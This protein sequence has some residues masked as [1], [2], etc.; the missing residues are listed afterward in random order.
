[1]FE[2]E[3]EPFVPVGDQLMT[4]SL[5]QPAENL[6]GVRRGDLGQSR[7]DL[8]STPWTVLSSKPDWIVEEGRIALPSEAELHLCRLK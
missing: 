4:S 1:M 2:I 7:L 6:Q 8:V 3:G 5:G